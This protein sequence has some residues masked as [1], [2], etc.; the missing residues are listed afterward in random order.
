MFN[1]TR[2]KCIPAAG[3]I[4]VDHSDQDILALLITMAICD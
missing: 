1:H 2:L 3:K 4:N